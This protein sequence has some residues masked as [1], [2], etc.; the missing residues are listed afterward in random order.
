[1]PKDFRFAPKHR[2]K[3]S[4][5]LEKILEFVEVNPQQTMC[6]IADCTGVPRGSV[7]PYLLEL[8]EQG[9][10]FRIPNPWRY[11]LASPEV[12][13]EAARLRTY[14]ADL[15]DQLEIVR[16]LAPDDAA[17]RYVV[18]LVECI[19]STESPSDALVQLILY[20][21]NCLRTGTWLAVDSR[22]Q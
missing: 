11:A 7:Q 3:K 20:A 17:R 19:E 15:K 9:Q 14:R 6:K 1:M 8:I 21:G 12:R 2:W 18:E 13:L 22:Q 4:E 10:I 16:R 5:A